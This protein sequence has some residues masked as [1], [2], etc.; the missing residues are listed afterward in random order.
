MTLWLFDHLNTKFLNINSTGLP[1]LSLLTMDKTNIYL[2]F[3]DFTTGECANL[4]LGTIFGNPEDIYVC[5]Q[6]VAGRISLDRK[7]PFDFI[8]LK[9]DTIVLSLID[10]DLPMPTTLQIS[11]WQ[12]S[13]IRRMLGSN[14]SYFRIV[15]HNPNTLKVRAITRAYNL[16]DEVL[17]D[18]MEDAEFLDV[19]Q[20]DQPIAVVQPALEVVVTDQQSTMTFNGEQ[21]HICEEMEVPIPYPNPKV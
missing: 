18:D 21:V 3:S 19:P 10:L 2:Q 4:Y 6:F 12:K 11:N 17:E 13:K 9:W 7:F 14:N 20:P 16:H 8:T 1:Y 15:A 5:G